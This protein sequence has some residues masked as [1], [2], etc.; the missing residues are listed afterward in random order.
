MIDKIVESSD[1]RIPK[2]AEFVD[3]RIDFKPH[4]TPEFA[5]KKYFA[6]IPEK[7]L[8]AEFWTW[9]RDYDQE[10]NR[11]FARTIDAKNNSKAAWKAVL[12]TVMQARGRAMRSI[13]PVVEGKQTDV[14][15]YDMVA[16][17]A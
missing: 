9:Y 5:G 3:L 14:N 7:E 17:K 2:A 10:D 6:W 13:H 1:P 16:W 12:K 8:L 15:A 11:E 4:R